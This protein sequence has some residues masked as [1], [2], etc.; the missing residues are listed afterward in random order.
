MGS[1]VTLR[2]EL[3]HEIHVLTKKRLL[4]KGHLGGEQQEKGAQENHS[5][6]WPAVSGFMVMGLVSRLSLASHLAWPI[7]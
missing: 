1:L 7:V 4:E 3:S 5:L 6:I 2:N